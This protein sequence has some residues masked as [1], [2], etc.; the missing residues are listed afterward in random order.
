MHNHSKCLHDSCKLSFGV[1]SCKISPIPAVL[2][3]SNVHL[4]IPCI[5]AHT[6][7][8]RVSTSCEILRVRLR[9]RNRAALDFYWLLKSSNAVDNSILLRLILEFYCYFSFSFFAVSNVVSAMFIY[10][11]LRMIYLTRGH[12]YI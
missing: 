3:Q 10:L 6:S 1:S 4:S 5:S 2:K 11:I 12:E 8:A 7:L 9:V